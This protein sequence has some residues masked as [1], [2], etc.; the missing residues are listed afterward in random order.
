MHYERLSLEIIAARS[1]W[2]KV[3]PP[4]LAGHSGVL[5]EFDFVAKHGQ[6]ILV[7]DICGQSCESDVLSE[8]DV[9]KTYI[10]KLDTGVPACIVCLNGKMTEGAV[11]LASEYGLKILRSDNMESAFKTRETDTQSQNRRL[12]GA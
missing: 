12:A 2:Q 5:H 1:Q 7:F 8:T 4:T 3:N 10:K 11:K 9:I 6:D